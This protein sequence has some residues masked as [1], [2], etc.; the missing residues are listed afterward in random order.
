LMALMADILAAALLLEEAAADLA[1]GDGRKT[2]IARLF[3]ESQFAP[4]ARRG[5]LPGRDWT[6]R[7]FE[8]LVNYQEIAL[9]SHA[10]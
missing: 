8:R 3:V 5:I 2:L 9:S 1:A 6:H 10:E 4:P 7:H